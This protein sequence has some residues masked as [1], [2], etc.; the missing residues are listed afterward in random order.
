MTD[1]PSLDGTPNPLKQDQI[2][3]LILLAVVAVLFL[4]YIFTSY[5]PNG[6]ND[7]QKEVSMAQALTLVAAASQTAQA[8]NP[9]FSAG[10]A[11]PVAT[12]I[13][14]STPSPLSSSVNSTQATSIQSKQVVLTA[15]RNSVVPSPTKN[16]TG[17]NNTQ[18][19]VPTFPASNAT[20]RPTYTPKPTETLQPTAPPTATPTLTA[21]QGPGLPG[22]SMNYVTGQLT[23]EKNF[24]CAQA[25]SDPGPVL[26]MCD[27]QTGNDLWYHVDLYGSFTIEITNLMVSVFQTYPDDAKSI[28]ILSFIAS[29]PYDGSDATE[30][31]KWLADTLPGIQS[32][33]DVREKF[34]GGIRFRLYGGP[35]GRYLEMGEP[36][37]Q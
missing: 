9:G 3:F 32:V 18:E 20:I 37:Q 12:Q 23:N 1:K 4:V 35:Q 25:G 22:L 27:F 2:L 36:A 17:Q 8:A 19:P 26:W 28:E 34:I 16:T 10:L 30:A 13:V 15:T 31:K 5:K 21:T 6:T 29:L 14:I 24:T 7:S 33:N 11:S